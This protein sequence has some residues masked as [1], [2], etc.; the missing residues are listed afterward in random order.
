MSLLNTT[1]DGLR[2]PGQQGEP[3]SR[4][5][6]LVLDVKGSRR[7]SLGGVRGWRRDQEQSC[8]S[9]LLRKV[10]RRQIR[11]APVDGKILS[12]TTRLPVK[13]WQPA[14]V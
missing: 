7:R 3:V 5:Q 9:L 8:K 14:F 1:D 6:S 10:R 2:M 4:A 13:A 11:D 12:H